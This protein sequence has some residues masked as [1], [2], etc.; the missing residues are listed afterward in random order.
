MNKIYYLTT[1]LLIAFL[2]CNSQKSEKKENIVTKTEKQVSFNIDGYYFPKDTIKYKEIEVLSI[3]FST[4]DEVDES[5]S[6]V[7]NKVYL[8]LLDIKSGKRIELVAETF[9][10]KNKVINLSV[11]IPDIGVFSFNGTFLGKNGPMNDN[12]RE[13]ETIVMKGKIEIGGDFKKETDFSYFAG[14]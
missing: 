8:N 1:I 14:D 3:L 4:K 9:Q 5:N 2:S 6:N 10:L 11:S 12:V 13:N 7:I